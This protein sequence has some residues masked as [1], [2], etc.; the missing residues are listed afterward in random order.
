MRIRTFIFGCTL[1]LALFLFAQRH[2][3]AVQPAGFRSVV[4]L[5]HTVNRNVPTYEL[6]EKA[7]YQVRTVAT[8]EKDQYFAREISLPEHFGTHIDAPAHFAAGTW[9]VD[10][11]PPERLVTPL[12]V[13]D[14]R[15]KVK[16]D[17]DY[18]LAVDDIAKWEQAHGQIPLGA[19]VMAKTG[20]SSRWNSVKDYRNADPKGIMHFPGYSEDAAKFLVEG[21]QTLA[22][23]IDTLSVDYGPSK[24]F[25]VH[26]YT[27]AHSLYHLENVANLDLVPET[28]ATVVVAP[29]K[30]E[31][32]SG[33][34][35]RILALVR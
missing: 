7:A 6:S 20:W 17:P 27:L 16:N 15:E 23:G 14:V 12:V 3:D 34:P 22:L 5:T 10:Q 32:G 13:I 29:M 19:V 1:A 9:T 33:G 25:E 26:R 2:L 8:I 11:I 18:C 28:G 24:N 30:L 35:V 31:G 4:D 21:R